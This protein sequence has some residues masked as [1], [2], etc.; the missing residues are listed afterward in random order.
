MPFVPLAATV[1]VVL[2]AERGG[3]E[4]ENVIHYRYSGA[5]PTAAELNTLCTELVNNLLPVCAVLA[6]VGTNWVKIKASEMSTAGG[7]VQEQTVFVPGVALG[8]VLPGNV[9]HCLT[10]RTSFRGPSFR[11]RFYLFDLAEA[12]FTGDDVEIALLPFITGLGNAL[13]T[14]RVGGKFTPAVGSDAI[15]GSTI[16]NAVTFDLIADS[17]RRRLKK[18]GR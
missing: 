10:K 15:G 1:E 11:G 4:R 9:S 5:L 18:R 16:F 7:L 2:S 17:Q 12:Y 13:L 3:E 6:V 8:G 14:S